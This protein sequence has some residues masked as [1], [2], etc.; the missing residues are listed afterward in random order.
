MYVFNKGDWFQFGLFN[1]VFKLT[2]PQAIIFNIVL[3]F[4]N[5]KMGFTGGYEY[6]LR[7]VEISHKTYLRA[8]NDLINIGLINEPKGKK[9][10]LF[11]NWNKFYEIMNDYI[12]SNNLIGQNDPYI[13]N[14]YIGQNDLLENNNSLSVNLIGQNDLLEPDKLSNDIGQ[15]DLYIY[16]DKLDIKH[17]KTQNTTKESGE[18]LK[19]NDILDKLFNDFWNA[20]PKK[21]K[22]KA[23]KDWFIENQNI[24]TDNLVL[25]MI[26]TIE[27][28]KKSSDWT[29]E[30]GRFIPSPI[31][32]L[33]NQSWNDKPYKADNEPDW[34]DEIIDNLGK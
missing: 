4:S 24:I 27:S 12:K 30:K 31:N 19:N 18:S 10:P 22:Y 26:D 7:A 2:P 21:T 11:I 32:W 25:Q 3:S 6:V 29:K 1:K 16:Q 33:K 14:L 17:N 23:C 20:Y 34:L 13:N 8:R 28:F 9:A 5:N 15:N